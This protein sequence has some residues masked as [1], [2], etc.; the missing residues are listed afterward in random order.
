MKQIT[1]RKIPKH[2]YVSCT[3]HYPK[4]NFKNVFEEQMFKG[5]NNIQKS[6][7]SNGILETFSTSVAVLMTS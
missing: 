5:L 1:V 2:V 3:Y 7:G 4:G 6:A